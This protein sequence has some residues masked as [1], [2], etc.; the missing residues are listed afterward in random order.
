VPLDNKR[1]ILIGFGNVVITMTSIVPIVLS[2]FVV[3]LAA[4]LFYF[5]EANKISTSHKF[6]H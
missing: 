1:K 3:I 6:S 2:L 5:M 4:G